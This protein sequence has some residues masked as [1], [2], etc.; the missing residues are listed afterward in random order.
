MYLDEEL[1][2][3]S[4]Q[5]YEMFN[6]AMSSCRIAFKYYLD[7][8]GYDK[9]LLINDDKVNEDERR[10]E[11]L[12]MQMMLKEKIYASDLR[13]VTG[14]L[15]MIQDIERIGDHAYDIKWMS[16]D[17]KLLDDM[18]QIPGMEELITIVNSLMNDS[19]MALVKMD[20]ELASDVIQR[21]NLADKK[22]WEIIQLLGN[23]NDQD[24]I[25]GKNTIYQAHVAKFLE[26]IGD[27]ATNIAEWVIYI[28]NGYHK[29][30]VII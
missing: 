21:D 17:I 14:L 1:R 29:D 27:Q 10:I 22:Y 25:G 7:D 11:S 3:V 23:L 26:R 28:I 6:D 8:Q 9:D 20:N 15:K 30:R 19:L 13:K 24:K 16:D 5:V 12:C 18:N 2:L 4:N